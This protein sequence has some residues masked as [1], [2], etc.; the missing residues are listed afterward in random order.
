MCE[1]VEDFGAT[2]KN[3]HI[4]YGNVE[5]GIPHKHSG[6]DYYQWCKQ[7]GGTYNGQI[8]YGTRT[9]GQLFGCRSYDE[10]NWHWCD[11]GDGH[12]H[13]QH[14]TYPKATGGGFITSITCN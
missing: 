14:L 4:K 11:W 7:L 9:G 8:T 1:S 10:S 12:W 2:C 3:P 13:N 5:G 6:N